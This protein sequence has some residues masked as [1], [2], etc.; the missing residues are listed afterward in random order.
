MQTERQTDMTKLTVT[1]RNFANGPKNDRQFISIVLNHK[2]NFIVF[3]I[4]NVKTIQY[5]LCECLLER[6]KIKYPDGK[7]RIGVLIHKH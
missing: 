5:I 2:E 6:N 7:S 4:L 3:F 1:L